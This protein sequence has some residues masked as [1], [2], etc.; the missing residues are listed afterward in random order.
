MTRTA[1]LAHYVLPA[2]SFL[3]R[4]EIHIEPKHQRVYL[5][6]KVVDVPGI[7]DEYMLWHDLARRLGFG[8]RFFPWENET[9]VNAYILEPSEFTLE[10]LEAHPAGIQYSP[11][12][13]QKH[14]SRPL[15]TP[16]GKLEFTSAYLEKL[17][18]AAMPEYV[19]P[20]HLRHKKDAYPLL[21]TTGARKTLFYHSRHQNLKNFRKL[22]PKAELEIH[23]EDAA[24]LGIE[25]GEQVRVVSAMGALTVA[26]NIVHK[27]ELRR[28]V[29][30][31]Y[32]GW[33]EWPINYTTF[34]QVNDPISGFPLLKGVPVRIEK[35]RA[36]ED[37][38]QKSEPQSGA[39]SR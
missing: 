35:A 12:K 13:Y 28:G 23:P 25:N 11:L 16:S 7:K 10:E 14:L 31:M 19:R 20:Y 15:P 18:Y 33:E 30:E 32:H 17:G 3:E 24:E 9:Q 29:V 6:R 26:A 2:A 5:T 38:T 37:G 8:E 27:A 21:L 22:H 39:R 1:Q 34:D 36:S 4:S